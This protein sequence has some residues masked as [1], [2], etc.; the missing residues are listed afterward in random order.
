[1]LSKRV[2]RPISNRSIGIFTPSLVYNKT[3]CLIGGTVYFFRLEGASIK[4]WLET[5]VEDKQFVCP[6]AYFV[7]N[8]EY[9]SDPNKAK[10]FEEGTWKLVKHLME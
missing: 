8:F 9:L 4:K 5:T 3:E 1:M 2:L 6:I 7:E 10:S